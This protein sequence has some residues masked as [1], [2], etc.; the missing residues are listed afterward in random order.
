M[1][2]LLAFV[3]ANSEGSSL[4]AGERGKVLTGNLEA[5]LLILFMGSDYIVKHSTGST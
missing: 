1:V 2:V 3:T 4:K 5:D